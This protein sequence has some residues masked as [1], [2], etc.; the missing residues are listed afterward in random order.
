MTYPTQITKKNTLLRKRRKGTESVKSGFFFFICKTLKKYLRDFILK[1]EKMF[2]FK[3]DAIA[4]CY[5]LLNIYF[6]LISIL[7][8]SGEN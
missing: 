6:T 2:P 5:C 1:M 8:L 4:L 3:F 7:R